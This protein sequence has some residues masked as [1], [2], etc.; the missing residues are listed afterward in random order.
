MVSLIKNHQVS[1]ENCQ[2]K[3]KEEREMVRRAERIENLEEE[4]RGEVLGTYEVNESS[5]VF[6]GFEN[7]ESEEE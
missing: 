1:D 5:E 2:I 4:S 7:E 3:S 6:M